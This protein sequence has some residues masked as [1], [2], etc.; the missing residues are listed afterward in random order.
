MLSKTGAIAQYLVKAKNHENR[1]DTS[2]Y[3]M[4]LVFASKSA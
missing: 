1:Q 2:A 3:S 4:Q